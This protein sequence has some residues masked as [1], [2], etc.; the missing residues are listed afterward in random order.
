M[1]IAKKVQEKV[2]EKVQL[3]EKAVEASLAVA[4]R[5]PALADEYA[6]QALVIHKEICDLENLIKKALLV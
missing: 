6:H 1:N 5:N 4:E 2:Q 3:R